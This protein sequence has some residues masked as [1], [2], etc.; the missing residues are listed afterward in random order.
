MPVSDQ[1]V[2]NGKGLVIRRSLV[3]LFDE[4]DVLLIK[5]AVTKRL[6]AGKYNGIGGHVQ[7]GETIQAGTERELAEE[8]G[9]TGVPLTLCGTIVIDTGPHAWI[10]ITVFSGVYDSNKP[11]RPSIEGN[12]EWHNLKEIPKLP[13]VEDLLVLLEKVGQMKNSG[14][15]FFG[16]YRYDGQGKLSTKFHDL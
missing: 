5:G 14:G 13:I 1:G 11:V 3:F 16:Y 10:L 9:I 4:E 6:W 15:Q 8:T 12:L 2:L 7:F